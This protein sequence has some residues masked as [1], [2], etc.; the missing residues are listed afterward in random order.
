VEF[1]RT[2]ED[3]RQ[4]CIPYNSRFEGRHGGLHTAVAGHVRSLTC[5]PNDPYFFLLHA[6]VDYYFELFLHHNNRQVTYPT[7]GVPGGHGAADPMKPF[8]GLVLTVSN[9]AVQIKMRTITIDDPRICQ[10]VAAWATTAEW[11]H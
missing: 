9:T 1:I 11:N 6:G 7:V 3:Y 2:Q 8:D 4:L 5:A 10:S